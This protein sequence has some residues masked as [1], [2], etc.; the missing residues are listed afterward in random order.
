MAVLFV[1]AL[2]A[3]ACDSDSSDDSSDDS[4]NGGGMDNA[5]VL[6]TP[7]PATGEPF[8]VGFILERGGEGSDTTEYETAGQATADYVNEYQGGIEGRPLEITF[9]SDQSTTAGATACVNELVQ[10]GVSAILV[11]SLGQGDAAA[12]AAADAGIPYAAFLGA[13][14]VELTSP[15]AVSMSGSS[16]AILGSP[17]VVME[18]EGLTKL[19]ILTIDV[20]T[21]TQAVES[22]AVPQYEAAG[23]EVELVTAA[24]GTPDLS[25]NVNSAPDSELWL[26]LGD[27]AFCTT[28]FQALQ[29]QAPGVPVIVANQCV[30]PDL[31]DSLPD[32]YEGVTAVAANR[33]DPEDE[34]TDLYNAVLD[35]F[36]DPDD[37][38]SGAQGFL[39]EGF[40]TVLGFDRLME[41]YT[42]DGTP[43]T[44]LPHLKSATGALPLGGGIE[45]TC[46]EPP[47][48]FL[49]AMCSV[50]GYLIELDTDGNGVGFELID[51]AS[52]FTG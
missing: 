7:D 23:L 24:P 46:G 47:V 29:T 20:P 30:E 35:E 48:E 52:F 17:G 6:G 5:E 28:A 15:N 25:A 11:G 10:D 50:S 32:G 37:V 22:L 16:L 14:T 38:D 45:M 51:V 44:V 40:S 36:A 26:L 1:V 8:R 9:C 42:G 27:A 12:S 13:S 49:S 2:V 39:V 43:E 4:S 41:G 3:V 33:L 18:R 21:A 19:G 31:A 34:E